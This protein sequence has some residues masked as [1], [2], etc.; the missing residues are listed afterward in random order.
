M[1]PFQRLC[2]YVEQ[3]SGNRQPLTKIS[4]ILARARRTRV[5]EYTTP[6]P[7]RFP[8]GARVAHPGIL[9]FPTSALAALV[10]TK[11]EASV[12]GLPGGTTGI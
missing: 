8:D 4:G 2:R 1:S 10:G 5:L 12:A 7:P 11:A 6:V 3:E 9:E